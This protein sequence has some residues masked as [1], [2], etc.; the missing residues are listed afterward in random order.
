CGAG[1]PQNAPLRA[2]GTDGAQQLAQ[3]SGRETPRRGSRSCE[4]SKGKQCPS[5]SDSNHHKSLKVCTLDDKTQS[6]ATSC[7]APLE[8][9]S[10]GIR[11]VRSLI[12]NQMPR[13]GLRVR[14]P[15]P[16]LFK[17]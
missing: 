7:D 17:F 3:P 8:S 9:P 2:T 11:M 1:E 16:P 10:E 15:C 6:L 13:K 12:R 5:G 4:P 14:V